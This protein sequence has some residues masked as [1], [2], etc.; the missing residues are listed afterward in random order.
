MVRTR[1]VAAAPLSGCV[2][3]APLL[4]NVFLECF[5]RAH[6]PVG[7]GGN[8][9][10]RSGIFALL[11]HFINSFMLDHFPYAVDGFV[12]LILVSSASGA[13]LLFILIGMICCCCCKRK[14]EKPLPLEAAY[15]DDSRKPLL[16]D[17]DYGIESRHPKCVSM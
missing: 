6:V 15:G 4:S 1:T 5:M 2:F 10:V 11:C 9:V 17:D 16:A 7:N 12:F 3:G 8:A 14:Q 13:A